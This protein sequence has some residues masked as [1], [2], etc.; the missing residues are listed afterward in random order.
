MPI[1]P[2]V[3]MSGVILH[4]SGKLQVFKLNLK[5]PAKMIAYLVT[6]TDLSNFD[7]SVKSS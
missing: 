5:D 1:I 6:F 7:T 2:Y 3:Y 4:H